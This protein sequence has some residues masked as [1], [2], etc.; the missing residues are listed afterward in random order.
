MDGSL[1]ERGKS[2]ENKFFRERDNE[3]VEKM[4]AEINRTEAREALAQAS[5]ISDAAVLDAMLDSQVTAESLTA[6]SLVPLV[7]V[8]WADGVME[9]KEIAA[10]SQAAEKSGIATD[11][12]AH[13]LLK[14][15]LDEKPADDL[16]ESWHEYVAALKTSLDAAAFGQLKSTVIGRAREVADAAG[17]ILGFAKTSDVES[18]VIDDLEKA[19]D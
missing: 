7:V 16:Q 14:S 3:L 2:L 9:A 19:F 18:A 5:G 10:I 12:A 1:F 15:W 11:S 13:G 8:A 17:G 4:R 6:I